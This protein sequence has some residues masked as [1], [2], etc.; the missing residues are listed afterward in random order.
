MDNGS[1]FSG[2]MKDTVEL[3]GSLLSKVICR[4]IHLMGVEFRKEYDYQSLGRG[5]LAKGS[6]FCL[7]RDG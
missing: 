7:K 2:L 6:K 1:L 4:K 3:E 5:M